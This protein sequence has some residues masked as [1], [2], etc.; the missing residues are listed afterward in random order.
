MAED[1]DNGPVA[2][3]F[4]SPDRLT[5]Q[6]VGMFDT[7]AYLRRAL[8]VEQA[9]AAVRARC[10]G[11]RQR[12]LF[13]VELRLKAWYALVASDPGLEERLTDQARGQLEALAR[14]VFPEGERPVSRDRRL[15]AHTAWRDLAESVA[16]FN[17]RWRTFVETLPLEPA[18]RAIAG[19][20]RYYVFEKECA[21]GSAWVAARGFRPMAVLS[22]EAL[23]V[24]FPL[25]PVL[26][27]AS[28]GL[29]RARD[30]ADAA[31]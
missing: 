30:S 9:I 8:A 25:L 18:N 7:P 1:T 26:E 21:L 2:A 6:L 11:Q 14:M 16:R 5:R 17:R 19:Y 28:F 20:N 24:E 3:E 27:A 13:G 23:L 15:A 12:W 22:C 4:D 10:E 31:R 29:R